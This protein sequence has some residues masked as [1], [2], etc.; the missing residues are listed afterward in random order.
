LKTRPVSIRIPAAVRVA[1]EEGAARARRDFSS[2]A[3]EM[4]EEAVKMRRIPG[5]VFADSA[6]GRCARVAGTNLP[7]YLI[8]QAYRAMGQDWDRLRQSYDWLSEQELRAPVAYAEAYPEE[9]ERRIAL[10][11]EWTPER[12]WTTHPFMRPPWR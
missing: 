4:L 5:I 9:I 1:I 12:V 8:V 3:N 6:S 11:Q 7:V 2:I 10:D